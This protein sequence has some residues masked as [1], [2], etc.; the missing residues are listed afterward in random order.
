MRLR[1][2]ISVVDRYPSV[3]FVAVVGAVVAVAL[4]ILGL[5][6][7]GFHAPW[8]YAGVMGPLC[9]G[10]RAARL[11]MVGDLG[12]GW[13]YNPLGVLAALAAPVVT[14]RA[15]AG[16][17]SGRWLDLELRLGRTAMWSAWVGIG[18]LLVA[19]TVRQQGIADL[20]MAPG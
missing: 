6:P 1:L 14:L 18:A 11:T 15:L 10:T 7:I 4:L 5:P 16:W 19:L 2:G 8:H 17:L 12:A 13:V 3:T 9:G 20:L